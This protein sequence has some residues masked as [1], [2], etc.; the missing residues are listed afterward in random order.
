MMLVCF[1]VPRSVSGDN[2]CSVHIYRLSISN[3]TGCK[4][5]V[6]TFRNRGVGRCYKQAK[7]CM[8]RHRDRKALWGDIKACVRESV[9]F[10][11]PHT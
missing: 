1:S 2:C 8:R 4:R 3:V 7:L 6:R 10:L 5:M 9:G 11:G